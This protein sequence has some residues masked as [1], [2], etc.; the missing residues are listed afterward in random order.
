MVTEA[1]VHGVVLE[2]AGE[3]GAAGAP[4]LRYGIERLIQ[5][6]QRQVVVDLEEVTSIT[7][8]GVTALLT[9]FVYALDQGASLVVRR[10]RGQAWADLE[11]SP[12]GR[13]LPIVD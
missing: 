9:S 7:L 10:P 1:R 12:A 8:A 6:G 4:G 2:A 3:L 11:H 13:V 5:D